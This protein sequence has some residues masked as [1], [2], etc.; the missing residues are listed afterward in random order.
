MQLLR[1]RVKDTKILSL[2]RKFRRAGI[3]EQGS[4]R[5]SRL[6]T[7]QGGLVSPFLANIYL[8]ARDRDM[9]RYA[10]LPQKEREKRKRRNEAN[11][12]YVR[13]A[14][15]VVGLCDGTKE[16]AEARRK[17]RYEFLD[18]ELTLELSVEKTTVTP[19]QDGFECL[20]F[21]ID[22]T[23][24]GSGNWAPRIRSPIRAMDKVKGKIRAALSPQTHSDSVRTKI[25]GRNSLI[26]GWC[27]YDQTTS[28]PSRLVNTLDQEVFWRMA[29]WLGRN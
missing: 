13:Y 12:L 28:S 1:R 14:D 20:G 26:G 9:E 27:R 23:V 3:R 8:H 17:A 2:T 10:D 21:A 18:T 22:R 16:H 7:P 19:L 29:H 5:H 4:F 6:G 25:L 11:F 24:V 15:D